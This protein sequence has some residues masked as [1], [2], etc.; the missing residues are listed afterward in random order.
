MDHDHSPNF[1]TGGWCDLDKLE[2][3]L[4]LAEERNLTRA[5]SRLFISQPTL[6]NYINRLEDELGIKLFDRTVQPI[7]VTEAG[8]IY[9]ED[10]KKIQNREMVLRSKLDSLKR[11]DDT[12]TVGIPPVR[13]AYDLPQVV[14]RFMEHYPSLNLRIDNRM[15]EELEKDLASGQID[16]VIGMLSMVYPNVHYELLQEDPLSLLVPRSC[17]CV[18]ELSPEEGTVQNPHTLDFE[19]LNEMTMLLPRVGGGHYRFAM[20]M[21]ERHGIVPK[22]TVNCGN[23]NLLYQLIGEGVGFLFTSAEPFVSAYSQYTDKIVFCTLQGDEAIQKSYIGYL[24]DN[25]RIQLVDEFIKL[26]KTSKCLE[27]I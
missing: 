2:Y 15:E 11:K 7:R 18:A 22:N 9:I 4:T 8:R 27:G 3:V 16:V 10:K 17:D 21:M 12:F 14:G 6:T 26:M 1:L 20:R 13:G 23:M 19:C 5:A 25:P 24:E